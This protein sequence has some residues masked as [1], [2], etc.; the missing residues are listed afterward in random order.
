MNATTRHKPQ[1][2]SDTVKTQPQTEEQPQK[3]KRNYAEHDP[4]QMEWAKPSIAGK[5]FNLGRTSIYE[6][7]AEGKIKSAKVGKARLVSVASLR[8]Y[9]EGL[10]DN[11]P[12]GRRINIRPHVG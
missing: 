8:A 4:A 10:A 9:I 12:A 6:L 11:P 5:P 2:S 3:K 1:P 7:I